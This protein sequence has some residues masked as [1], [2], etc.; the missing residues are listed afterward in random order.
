MTNESRNMKPLCDRCGITSGGF[1]MSMFNQDWCCEVCIATEVRHPRWI[2]ARDREVN[3]VEDGN[4]NYE[5][6]GL[7][8]NYLEW[9]KLELKYCTELQYLKEQLT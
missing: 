9:A 2:E 6:I 3:E 4:L 5:G 7:P 8:Q 1:K